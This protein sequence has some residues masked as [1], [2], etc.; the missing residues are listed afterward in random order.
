VLAW[1]LL[2]P[3]V[4]GEILLGMLMPLVV[5]CVSLVLADREYRRDPQLLT[6]FMVKAFVGKMVVFGLYVVTVV[7]ALAFDPR[8]FIISFTAYFIALHLV[9]A[10]YLRRL[11]STA[12]Q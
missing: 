1:G 2:A 4:R 5:A 11:F 3:G 12:T 7:A 10:L 6:P 8:P 9:E